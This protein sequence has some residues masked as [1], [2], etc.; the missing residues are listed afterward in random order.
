MTYH[1]ESAPLL[2]TN[3]AVGGAMSGLG[4]F[5]DIDATNGFTASSG[6]DVLTNSGQ[7]I[8]LR[9]ANKGQFNGSELI[10]I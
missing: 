5:L 3:W 4:N 10:A 2:G 1:Y 7:Q 6:L 8:K 9:I